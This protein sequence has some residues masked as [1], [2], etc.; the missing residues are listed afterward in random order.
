MLARRGASHCCDLIG[1]W[2]ACRKKELRALNI[3][4]MGRNHHHV[5]LC[6]Y[7]LRVWQKATKIIHGVHVS[8]VMRRFGEHEEC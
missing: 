6:M 4:V 1:P 3:V 2:E 8:Q 7:A 5:S